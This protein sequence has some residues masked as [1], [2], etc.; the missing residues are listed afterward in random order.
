MTAKECGYPLIDTGKTGRRLRNLSRQKDISV[1]EI[2]RCLGLTSNQAVY[3]WFNGKCLPTLNNF[4]A[5]SK[6]LQTTME[7]LL[8]LREETPWPVKKHSDSCQ[9]FFVFR[10]CMNSRKMQ[11]SESETFWTD[12]Y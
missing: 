12:D 8:V 5:L 11:V 6:L 4:F 7:D 2:Q 1:Q 9:A 3:E 10:L